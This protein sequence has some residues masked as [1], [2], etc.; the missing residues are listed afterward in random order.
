MKFKVTFTEAS[1]EFSVQM[2]SIQPVDDGRSETWLFEMN[3]GTVVEKQ[4]VVR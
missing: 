3:N 1:K 4:V 2:G